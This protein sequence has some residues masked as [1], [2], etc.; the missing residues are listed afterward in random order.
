MRL[1]P[2]LLLLAG[3]ATLAPR[4]E[5]DVAATFAGD[6]MRTLTTPDLELHYPAAYAEQAHRVAARAT[7]CIRAL[8]AHQAPQ[9]GQQRVLLFLT[10][11][12]FNNAYVSGQTLG[13]PLHSVAPLTVTDEIFH[14]YGLSAADSGDI[15][16]HEMF[17]VVHFEQVKGFWRVVNLAFGPVAPPQSLLERWFT[18]GAAQYYE[19]R[20][21][22]LTGRPHSPLYKGSFD[23]FVNA[24]GGELGP[25]DLSLSQRELTPYSGAYL[26]GLYFVE[27]LARTYGEDRLWELMDRQGASFIFP[28]AVTLR[29]GDVYGKTLGEL[30]EDFSRE[31]RRTIPART[32]PASQRTLRPQVGQF[33]RLATHPATGTLALITSGNDEVHTLRILG[34]DGTVRAERRLV[35]LLPGRDW[36]YSS[37]YS[38]SG[39]S[40]SA[41]GRFLFLLNDDLIDR[42]D[43]RAQIWKLDVATLHTVRLWDDVGRGMGGAVSPDGTSYTFVEFPP[44]GGARVVELDLETGA[45]KIWL[46]TPAPI[47]LASPAWS[48]DH[49]RLAVAR[50]DADGWNLVLRE[51][52]GTQRRLTADGAFNYGPRW[53]DAS[54][55]LFVRATSDYLQVHRLDVDTGRLERLTDAPYGLIDPG[56]VPGGVAFVNRDGSQWSL[57]VAADAA[58]QVVTEALPTPPPEATLATHEPLD[59]EIERDQPYSGLDHLFVPQLRAPGVG[60]SV[61]NGSGSSSSLVTTL[62]ASLQGR[63]RLGWHTWAANLALDLPT[64]DTTVSLGY[65]NLQL[66][67][68]SLTALVGVDAGRGQAFWSGSVSVDRTFFT[69][70]LS[71]GLRAEQLRFCEGL[72]GQLPSLASAVCPGSSATFWGPFLSTSWAAAETTGYGGARRQLALSLD[73]A[74]FP[75]ALGSERDL[76]DLRASVAVG[77]PVP[78]SSRSSALLSVVGRALL[79]APAGALQVGGVWRATAVYEVDS[80]PLSG[81]AGPGVFLPGSLVEGLRGFEDHALRATAAAIAG[82]RYRYAFIIDRGFA[83]TLWLFPSIFFRQVDVEAFGVA[84]LTDHAAERWA[85]GVGGAVWLRMVGGGTLPLSLYYQLAG[86]F[87]F[88][89]PLLHSVGLAVE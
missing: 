12:N 46:E 35:Q 74:A 51:A 34:V 83:S 44:E 28:L 89:L 37:A 84:A 78:F 60:V 30:V 17:H 25:G 59:L 70:P 8:R 2:A 85:R 1:A 49:R 39:L 65:R 18:E 42:G 41:D 72:P 76:A 57:D 22:R 38:V 55:L 5:Q 16:C 13:E 67:P 32:R 19:G 21:E 77:I 27:Y 79:G 33:A 54:H 23:A 43:T 52:D 88:G 26:T 81:A 66:A 4:F 71:L 48:P 45:R 10:S 31:L 29:F 6:E 50:M 7:E 47:S 87:D 61:L 56:A 86:R 40:F 68:W 80:R 58:L 82:L 15:A 62:S 36:V 63:D 9:V 53:A 20:V 64:L 11:S 24:R 14:W 73:A 75:A 69:T 3:C